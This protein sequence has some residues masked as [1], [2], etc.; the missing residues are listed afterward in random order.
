[1]PYHLLR[2]SFGAPVRGSD[3]DCMVFRQILAN[4]FDVGSDLTILELENDKIKV[5]YGALIRTCRMV[6]GKRAPWS[7]QRAVIPRLRA[8]RPVRID[9]GVHLAGVG[10][11]AACEAPAAAEVWRHWAN[12]VVGGRWQRTQRLYMKKRLFGSVAC[13]FFFTSNGMDADTRASKS[14]EKKNATPYPYVDAGK[15]GAMSFVDEGSSYSWVPIVPVKR[16]KLSVICLM[17]NC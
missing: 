7:F 15:M 10:V 11:A 12:P 14:K 3:L 13:P 4:S 5:C 1:M 8:M 17:V 16:G 9:V 2:H 6:T